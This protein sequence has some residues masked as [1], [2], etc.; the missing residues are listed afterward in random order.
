MQKVSMDLKSTGEA[1]TADQFAAVLMGYAA[2]G[3]S[4]GTGRTT[5][6]Q[7]REGENSNVPSSSPEREIQF[8]GNK[9]MD[10]EKGLVEKP[11]GEGVRGFASHVSCGV[12][13]SC[14]SYS[15]RRLPSL[16]HH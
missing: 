4:S 6:I 1:P 11:T 14:R 2:E 12:V 9:I 16:F 5:S 15:P 3:M 13:V 10:K 8:P 7:T